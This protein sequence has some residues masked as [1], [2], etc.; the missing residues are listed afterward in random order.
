MHT[1]PATSRSQWRPALEREDVYYKSNGGN[2]DILQLIRQSGNTVLKCS[3]LDLPSAHPSPAW[4][5]RLLAILLQGEV[6]LRDGERYSEQDVLFTFRGVYVAA[7]H[8]LHAVMESTAP[9]MKPDLELSDFQE[10]SPAYRYPWGST[11]IYVIIHQKY[12]WLNLPE[13]KLYHCQSLWMPHV[14]CLSGR[15]APGF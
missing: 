11:S 12:F 2:S 13:A 10:Q 1:S 14:P 15:W 5:M 8:R 4:F 9:G 3:S 7:I 6:V